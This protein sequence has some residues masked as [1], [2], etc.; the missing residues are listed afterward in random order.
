MAL[1]HNNTLNLYFLAEKGSG[2]KNV[3]ISIWMQRE[4]S[5]K[6]Y[7]KIFTQRKSTGTENSFSIGFKKISASNAVLCELFWIKD[8]E[9]C[10]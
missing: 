2:K 5:L 7:E 1:V 9:I 3:Y 4:K 8:F 6:Y 10:D